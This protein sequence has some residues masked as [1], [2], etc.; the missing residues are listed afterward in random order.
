MSVLITRF[1][2]TGAKFPGKGSLGESGAGILQD[3]NTNVINL[4]QLQNQ[5]HVLYKKVEGTWLQYIVLYFKHLKI[6]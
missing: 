1:L 4:K 6:D 3:F 2:I 5:D